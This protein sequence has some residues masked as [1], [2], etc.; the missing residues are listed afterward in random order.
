[1]S[2]ILKLKIDSPIMSA[3]L[4]IYGLYLFHSLADLE[5]R[6]AD[7]PAGSV[8]SKMSNQIPYLFRELNRSTGKIM[9]A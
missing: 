9:N 1:M 8:D 4:Y 5:R 3:P 7:E 2:L 6:Y